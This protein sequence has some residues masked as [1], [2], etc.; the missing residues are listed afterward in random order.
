MKTVASKKGLDEK[1]S[2][3]P[4]EDE[5][6]EVSDG[7]VDSGNVRSGNGESCKVD[8]NMYDELCMPCG[9]VDEGL[10]VKVGTVPYKPIDKEVDEH[11]ATH[12]P[13]RSWCPACVRAK[14]P[15]PAHYT[16]KHK[17][18]I[19]IPRL[20][21][22]YMYMHSRASWHESNNCIE[23]FANENDLCNGCEPKRIRGK[24]DCCKGD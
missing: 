2:V 15:T 24:R 19:R 13:F 12:V 1:Q 3:R 14:A 17:G 16:N 21:M 4:D 22:D 8:G 20:S 9:D 18:G 11:E 10:K 23:G 6:M 5:K 7:V